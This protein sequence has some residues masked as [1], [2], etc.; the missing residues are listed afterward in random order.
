[1]AENKEKEVEVPD[2]ADGKI[3]DM[4]RY[5]YQV[6]AD[7]IGYYH[8][9]GAANKRNYKNYRSFTIIL[10]ALVT[11]VAS[12]TS[13]TFVESVGMGWMLGIAT[14]ILAAALTII[15]GL[16]QNFQWG[17]TWRDMMLT[18]QRLEK[19]RDRFLA[20][21]PGKRNYR[22]ELE[23]INELVLQETRAFFQRVL[24]SEAVPTNQPVTEENNA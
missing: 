9:A 11:L 24:D 2:V 23:I 5:V 18:A 14:P 10:G 20:T 7:Q 1:M 12:L 3:E 13:S 22:R 19:E 15:N 6:Y 16:G 8:R 4:D 17:A 21:P